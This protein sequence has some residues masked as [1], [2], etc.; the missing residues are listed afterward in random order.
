MLTIVLQFGIS[1]AFFRF[2]FDADDD[3]GR[4][5]VLRTSFWFTMTMAT[6]GL[7]VLVVFASQ[8]SSWLF[9]DPS[10]ANLVRASAVA[11]WAQLNYMQLTNLFRVEER[12]VAFV[13]ASLSNILLTVGTTLLLV[14]ALDK[15]P[16]RRHRRQL[17]GHADRLPRAP[18]LPARAARAPARAGRCSGR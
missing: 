12:S 7:I 15:G 11:L 13:I 10:A 4:R 3:A 2:Y 6:L 5:L 17:H 18:R 14:V 16:A 1:S 8:I 9:D